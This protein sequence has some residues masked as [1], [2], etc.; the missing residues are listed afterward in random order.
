MRW[1]H[2]EEHPIASLRDLGAVLEDVS[3][4]PRAFIVRGGLAPW[5]R[6]EMAQ[7]QGRPIRRRKLKKG[8]DDPSLVEV[9][10]PWLMIDIDNFPL[11]PSDDLAD[12]PESAIEHAISELL[13]PAFHD[14][15]AW[16][17][18]SSSAGF[19]AGMLK[20]HVF[21]WLSEP[22]DNLHIKAVLKQHAPGVDLAPFN[23][24]QPHYIAAPVIEGG[25]DPLPRRTGWR[26]G[27]DA[28]VTLPLLRTET[29]R[30]W[31]SS[32]SGRIG[33]DV[34]DALA[35]LGDGDGLQG[36]H[37]PLRTATMRYAK[38]C[39]RY[40]SRDDDSFRE[41]LRAAIRAAP[42]RPDRTSVDDY[43]ADHYLQ[44]L[45]DG[46]FA[47]LAGDEDIQTMQPQYAAATET[48][49]T[50]RTILGEHINDFLARARAWHATLS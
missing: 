18:L 12:D 33:G 31:A 16:W 42:R 44:R 28:A 20:V 48:I 26:K 4:D 46:A 40:G 11:R 29:S 22:A 35:L 1:F 19:S 23:A 8:D 15:E 5:V 6:D 3:G 7:G 47:L 24:A 43:L 37:V 30:Q 9:P 45:I 39:A 49:E 36:F 2:P 13:P 17:Q 14:T 10:C 41:T 38:R 50:T 25:H 27:S 32:S 34:E 21:F